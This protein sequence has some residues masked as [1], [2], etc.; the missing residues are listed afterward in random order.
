[1]PGLGGARAW[2]LLL[3]F[4]RE[5]VHPWWGRGGS[6]GVG[7][8][9]SCSDS[10]SLFLALAAQQAAAN[11]A[12][13]VLEQQMSWMERKGPYPW[14]MDIRIMEKPQFPKIGGVG[15]HQALCLHPGTFDGLAKWEIQPQLLLHNFTPSWLAMYLGLFRASW[16]VLQGGDGQENS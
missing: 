8:A 11:G 3:F 6:P 5:E 4:S 1:M 9:V 2:S 16:G 13:G 12:G 14:V 10:P 7:T 15:D